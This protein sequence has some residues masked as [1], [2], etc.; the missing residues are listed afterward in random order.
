MQHTAGTLQGQA[1]QMAG[2]SGLT[3]LEQGSWVGYKVKRQN[4]SPQPITQMHAL[5]LL[6]CSVDRITAWAEIPSSHPQS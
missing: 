1:W 3:L 5:L 4:P 2:G 6:K